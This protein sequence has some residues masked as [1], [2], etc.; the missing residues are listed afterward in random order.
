[1]AQ[2]PGKIRR[3][4]P[5]LGTFVEI[6]A[7]GAALAV[8]EAAIED[9]FGAIARVHRL[10]SFQDAA[11]DVSKLNREGAARGT[12]VDSWTYEVLVAALDVYRS[13]EGIFDSA[14]GPAYA[15]RSRDASSSAIELLPGNRVRFH[16]PDISIDLSG[17]AKGFAADR[18]IETLKRHGIP[19]ALVNAGGDLAASGPVPYRCY[20]RN[21]RTPS[22]LLCAATVGN[23]ALASSGAS[24][25]PHQSFDIGTP[26]II[27]PKRQAPVHAIAGATVRAR[28]CMIADALTKVVMIAGEAAG[29]VLSHYG[30]EAFM[31]MAGGSISCSRGWGALDLAA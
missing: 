15:S 11:S 6:C 20:I 1:M 12:E 19:S 7:E 31:V 10:M 26:A 3:A 5:L 18:A 16:R 21:P 2:A 29:G 25:D 24:F 17:I 14:A 30:A 22:Q 9:A 8:M 28:S 13:S 23:E 27:D 4:R